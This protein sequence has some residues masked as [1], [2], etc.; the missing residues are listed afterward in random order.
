MFQDSLSLLT[1]L[2]LVIHIFSA[3]VRSHQPWSSGL[4]LSFHCRGSCNFPFK[5]NSHEQKGTIFFFS[6]KAYGYE[7]QILMQLL[8][9]ITKKK[10]KQEKHIFKTEVSSMLKC[11][12]LFKRR[13]LT[14]FKQSLLNQTKIILSMKLQN[15]AS[16]NK[17]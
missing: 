3:A 16:Y 4:I 2:T 17:W 8:N 15:I 14:V 6:Q 7:I 12:D 5:K 13:L 1:P 9:K 11:F 10:K